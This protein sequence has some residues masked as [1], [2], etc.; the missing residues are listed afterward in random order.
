M[1]RRPNRDA[2]VKRDLKKLQRL[3]LY[4]PKTDHVTDYGKRQLSK[5]RNVL[6]GTATV[7]RAK[8]GRVHVASDIVT[9]K[10]ITKE[11]S[12]AERAKSY[13]GILRVKGDRIIV[14]SAPSTKPRFNARTGEITIDVKNV[15]EIKR[16]RLVPVKINSVDDLRALDSGGFYFALPLRKYGQ[17]TIDWINY[18][19]V[20]ELIQDITAYY[21]KPSL[22]RYVVLIPKGKLTPREYKRP[23]E[24]YE[25]ENEE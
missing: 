17:R 23:P 20:N 25:D 16:G 22:A 8:S 19:D 1:P 4:T 9:R 13:K 18:E 2:T 12:A 21:R 6:S 14:Q 7:V 24:Y 10:K 3:G 15:G 5:F 11:L